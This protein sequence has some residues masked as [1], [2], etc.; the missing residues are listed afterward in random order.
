MKKLMYSNF[1]KIMHSFSEGLEH[2]HFEEPMFKIWQV[3]KPYSIMCSCHN[4][5]FPAQILGLWAANSST[6]P[7]SGSKAPE[8]LQIGSWRGWKGGNN[9]NSYL[10]ITYD[11]FQ[12]HWLP[13]LIANEVLMLLSGV[14]GIFKTTSPLYMTWGADICTWNC[15]FSDLARFQT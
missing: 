1:K 4:L 8:T 5:V 10:G 11:W 15:L 9:R 7:R 2:G 6:Q 13:C 3:L 14:E 12:R